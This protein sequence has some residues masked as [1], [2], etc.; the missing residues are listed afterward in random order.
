MKQVQG[1]SNY[2]HEI[3]RYL[4]IMFEIIRKP[5]NSLYHSD[6]YESFL[7]CLESRITNV[8]PSA[9]EGI[10]DTVPDLNIAWVAM[11]ELFKLAG[12]IYLERASR[13]FSG[14]SPQIDTMVERA[15]VLLDDLETVSPTFPL[16]IVGCEAR[17]DGQ[18]MKILEHIEKAMTTSSLRSLYELRNIL[19]QIWVQDDLAVDYE[20]SYLNK[21]D[22][23]ISSYQ[24][25]PSFA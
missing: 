3:L 20:L 10:S 19:Q 6:E 2:S 22:A 17:T 9:V 21:L 23:V 25:I 11:M 1:V 12:L 14:I 7:R 15:Y 13:N 24:I 4:Y 16:L 8:V 5:T 18:R